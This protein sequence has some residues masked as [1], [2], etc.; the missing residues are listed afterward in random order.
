MFS[1]PRLSQCHISLRLPPIDSNEVSSLISEQD[2]DY[3]VQGEVLKAVILLRPK[4]SDFERLYTLIPYLEI[5]HS[6]E[7]HQADKSSDNLEQYTS[8]T[9]EGFVLPFHRFTK[10]APSLSDLKWH[11]FETSTNNYV[12]IA[13]YPIPISVS[14]SAIGSSVVLQVSIRESFSLFTK[15]V[16]QAVQ[17][18]Y[19][20]KKSTPLLSVTM[21]R[22]LEILQGFDVRYRFIRNPAGTLL[23]LSIRNKMENV[24]LK[25]SLPTLEMHATC[26]A[27][28]N[29]KQHEVSMPM[30][31]AAMMTTKLG[32]HVESQVTVDIPEKSCIVEPIVLLPKEEYSLVFRFIWRMDTTLLFDTKD[33]LLETPVRFFWEFCSIAPTLDSQTDTKDKDENG[34]LTESLCLVRWKLP[35]KMTAVSVHFSGPDNVQVHK[36]FDIHITIINRSTIDISQGL[37]LFK[38]RYSD[39]QKKLSTVVVEAN[40]S[41]DNSTRTHDSNALHIKLTKTA[42]L[43]GFIPRGGSITAKATATVTS[44]GLAKLPNVQLIDKSNHRHWVAEYPFEVFASR[45]D[46]DNTTYN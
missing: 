14:P 15:D 18:V 42:I 36:S 21:K 43:V 39:D 35:S 16:E 19:Q 20:R 17:F 33:P 26:N 11:P 4:D 27:E 44:S 32:Q 22:K 8:S 13:E 31:L 10:S 5:S 30:T 2:R 28:D 34:C 41:R 7:Y 3:A 1:P 23:C 46:D 12:L 9:N 40:L 38:E 45:M 6:F 24:G 37:L 25:L 29:T